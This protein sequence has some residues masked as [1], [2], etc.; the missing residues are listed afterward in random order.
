MYQILKQN[1]S[2]VKYVITYALIITFLLLVTVVLKNDSVVKS[3]EKIAF[4]QHPDLK[5]IKEFLL[6]LIKSP[7]ININYEI[8]SGDSIQKI[9]KKFKVQN[10][11]IQTIINQYKKYS[12][13]N[14]LLTGDKIDIIVEENLSKKSNS[15]AKFAIPIK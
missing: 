4:F 15:I 2:R 14:K 6:T 12:N 7:F 3:G 8:K 5:S 10:N 1:G 11:E 13:P 9:L